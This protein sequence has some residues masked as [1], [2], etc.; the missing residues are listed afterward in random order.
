MPTI[1]EVRAAL[2][3]V[4][5]SNGNDAVT[6]LLDNVAG[7]TRLT[8][9]PESYYAAVVKAAK[10]GDVSKLPTHERIQ[11]QAEAYWNAKANRSRGR[12]RGRGIGSTP[13][14]T[15]DQE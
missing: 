9:L 8:D 1:E 3:P 5:E 12:G 11:A 7:V 6:Q 13:G 2:R 15:D 4:L 14:R 10:S